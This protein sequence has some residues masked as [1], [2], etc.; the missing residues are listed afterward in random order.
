ME[1]IHHI[2][3]F[4]SS[5]KTYV[6]IGTFDGVHFGHQHI[7]KKL[8]SEAQKAGKKSV[9]LTF[10]PHPRMVLQKDSSLELINTIDE[11][12]YIAMDDRDRRAP[13]ALTADAPVA[14]AEH[15]RAGAWCINQGS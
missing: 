2:E 3:N 11:R 6:T 7:L 12:A 14:Q 13:I 1:I 10:F 8:V 15:R 5:Q 4:K 9:L